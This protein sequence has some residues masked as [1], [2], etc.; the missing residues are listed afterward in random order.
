MVDRLSCFFLA[1]LLAAGCDPGTV[2]PEAPDPRLSPVLAMSSADSE[3]FEQ[4]LSLRDFIFP[5]DH[6]PH[7]EFKLE[8]WYLVGNLESE[9]GRRFGYQLTFFRQATA[10]DEPER[11]SAWA[12][13]QLYM[14]H[15]AVT[16]VDGGGFHS[17]ERFSRGA[18][19]LAGAELEPFR[20]WVDDWQIAS[21]GD[22]F[23][24]LRVYAR[25]DGA[26]LEL[27]LDSDKPLV[28]QGEDGLSRKSAVPG[29]ASY[30]Y[31]YT[32]LRAEGRVR[33]GEGEWRVRGSGWLDREWS[34]SGLEENQVGW[35]WFALQLEDGRDLMFYQL[36]LRDGT[37]EPMSHGSLVAADGSSRLLRLADVELEVLH[38]WRSP[39]GTEYPAGWRLRLPESRLDLTVEPLLADQELDAAF[40][41]WEG[42]VRVRGTDG[43]DPVTGLGYVELVGYAGS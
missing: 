26:V 9:D 25:E 19:G 8:W 13:R 32:R 22:S 36:R 28:L 2:A 29:N 17:W 38:T 30:Y 33:I 24:P 35:D 40:R 1:S 34:T 11:A 14:A 7:P 18:A 5:R 43:G 15:F 6:G 20:V 42:A 23:L 27:A 41:Y 3:G 16:D 10:A 37:V 21:P 31:S 12:T 39:E 4:A